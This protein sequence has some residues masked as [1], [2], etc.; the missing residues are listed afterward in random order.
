MRTMLQR[1]VLDGRRGTFPLLVQGSTLLK[2]S[3]RRRLP[4]ERRPYGARSFG[5]RCPSAV[6]FYRRVRGRIDR[7]S[8]KAVAVREMSQSRPSNPSTDYIAVRC[9]DSSADKSQECW[10]RMYRAYALASS[11]SS[12]QPH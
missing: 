1:D 7:R 12:P 2:K 4:S 6:K 5:Q 10:I 11:A 3:T 8:V 9:R